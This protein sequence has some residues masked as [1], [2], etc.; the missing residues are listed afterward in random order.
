M[1]AAQ[2]DAAVQQAQAAGAQATAAVQG[3]ATLDAQAQAAQQQAAAAAAQAAAARTRVEQALHPRAE[4]LA[5]LESQVRLAQIRL[6]Q[7]QSQDEA[8]QIAA[9]QAEVAR[10]A[11]QQAQE[12]SRP[13][14]VRAAQAAL[15]QAETAL[16]QLTT[17]PVRAEDVNVA[18]LNVEAAT[19]A[20]E[21]A[22]EAFT[23]A[24]AARNAAR[25]QSDHLPPGMPRAQ[26]D[27][28][29]AQAETGVITAQ[30]T[31][32][33]RR[34]QRDQAQAT[35]DK[36][37]AGATAWD[38][39]LAQERVEAA[40]A[41]LDLTKNP[42]PARVRT[43]QLQ[44][45]QAQLQLAARRKQI[46]FE[47]QQAEEGIAQAAAQLTKA[48]QPSAYDVQALDEQA[49]AAEA[50]AEAALAQVEVLASQRAAAEVSAQGT[51]S[52]AAAAA[53]NV[54]Q[55]EA[56]LALRRSP[57]TA[58]DVRAARA[59]VQ[60]AQANVDAIKLQQADAVIYAPVSGV[61][62]TRAA[63][64]GALVGPQAPIA[65][66][67][68]DAVE[69]AVPVEEARLAGIKP[70]QPVT[71]AAAAYPGEAL[72]GTVVA[73]APAGD[74]R[75]RAFTARIRPDD[76]AAGRLRP[77]M[78]VQASIATEERAAVPV[79]PRDA[80]LQKEGKAAV[81]VVGPDNTVTLRPV[82]LGL[83]ADRLAEIAEGLAP[84]EQVVVVGADDLRDGQRVAPVPAR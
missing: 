74:P 73:V 15:D 17:Q 27:M 51:G 58:E 23:Q 25:L 4:D 14:Q 67:V 29:L 83:M 34:V 11:L 69:V 62:A 54:R 64:T 79:V 61:V 9:A 49:R 82:R 44:V 81:F 39:R 78:S 22:Q 30:A 63:S 80:L 53:A 20:L 45:E 1:A 46:G 50:Q 55:A 47:A 35:Y 28:A 13:E 66:L 16:A 71:L 21:S 70:G 8:V 33:Q 41:Q 40:K 5:F 84:G 24:V 42:D 56:A 75:S 26:A 6:A 10:V 12:G 72:G 65:T 3:V 52:Q 77:G 76:A 43:A 60:Q 68:S 48:Q 32:D 31:Y 2:R 38:V 37:A 19:A 7:A 59:A 18:R 57:Y 36:L